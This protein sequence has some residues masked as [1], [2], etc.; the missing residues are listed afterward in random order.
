M[1]FMGDWKPFE[2]NPRRALG[3]DHR[4]RGPSKYT[5]TIRDVAAVARL[6][7]GTIRKYQTD[8]RVSLSS[9]ESVVDFLAPLTA[10]G[11][12]QRAERNARFREVTVAVNPDGTVTE[13]LHVFALHQQPDSL[14]GAPMFR[15]QCQCGSVGKWTT[16]GHAESA[17]RKH[18]AQKA[19]RP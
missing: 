12:A 3:R 6:S 16:H 17:G 13:H 18:V 14:L 19:G 11:L 10:K 9:L 2:G 4:E 15:W 8:G 7:V 1:D 5:Y